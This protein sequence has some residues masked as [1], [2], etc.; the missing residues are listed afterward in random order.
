V[1]LSTGVVETVKILGE[2]D[3]QW[4]QKIVA[5]CTGLKASPEELKEKLKALLAPC[6]VPKEI[7]E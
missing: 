5:R 1:I 2:P 7:W 3:E 6:K 4:G